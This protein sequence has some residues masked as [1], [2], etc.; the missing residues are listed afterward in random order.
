[1]PINRRT[2]KHVAHRHNRI[3]SAVEKNE[4]GPLAATW[5]YLESVILSQ[6][7]INIS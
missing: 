6:E 7:K 1:M 4:T 5:I 2:D 3:W